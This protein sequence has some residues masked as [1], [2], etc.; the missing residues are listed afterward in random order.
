MAEEVFMDIPVVQRMAD[1]FG[2]FSDTLKSVNKTLEA[3][4]N[5]L[6]A[7]A[8]V[9]LVGGTALEKYVGVIKPNVEKLAEKMTELQGD[10]NGAIKAFRDGDYTGS[11]RFS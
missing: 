5:M 10:I 9:G 2:S 6:K 7:T 1:S 4:M 8:F 3:G 11:R